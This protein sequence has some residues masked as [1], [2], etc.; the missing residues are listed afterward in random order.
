MPKKQQP[1]VVMATFYWR[2]LLVPALAVTAWAVEE[3]AGVRLVGY[4]NEV[5]ALTVGVLGIDLITICLSRLLYPEYYQ[6]QRRRIVQL[7]FGERL[8]AKFGKV[9]GASLVLVP[10][11]L[12]AAWQKLGGTDFRDP[13]HF[14]LFAVLA[15]LAVLSTV[16]GYIFIRQ[17]QKR[18]LRPTML[19]EEKVSGVPD[20]PFAL[21]LRSFGVNKD[22]DEPLGGVAAVS[23][24]GQIISYFFTARRT[25]EQQLV[26]ALSLCSGWAVVAFG[27]PAHPGERALGA[28]RLYY[29]PKDD[30]WKKMVTKLIHKA[31]CVVRTTGET[32]GLDWEYRHVM[33]DVDPRRVIILV[34]G[35]RVEH[36]RFQRFSESQGWFGGNPLPEPV[37][38]R[39][40]KASSAIRG[41][42]RF[43]GEW[44][45]VFA[46]IMIMPSGN[47][48]LLKSLSALERKL[49]G[50]IVIPHR[51]NVGPSG[52]SLVASARECRFV[53][54]GNNDS[55]A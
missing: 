50:E 47:G 51:R 3:A 37:L 4:M 7:P 45:G 41:V 40:G 12:F 9:I 13:W 30:G 44:V 32:G 34:T 22:T 6:W 8:A 28:D 31:E 53:D 46:P 54:N 27:H 15:L 52:R 43:D 20:I 1:M 21:Y 25:Q 16:L 29:L 35:G 19:V 33:A 39:K 11:V 2:P 10:W 48:G 24:N 5:V 17:N 38:A 23:G 14:V 49:I 36:E 42:L 26:R 55:L 18:L